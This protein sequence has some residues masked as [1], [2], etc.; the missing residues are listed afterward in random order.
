MTSE[1][2]VRLQPVS[3]KEATGEIPEIYEST[4]DLL[5]I[6]WTAAIFQG[7]AMYPALL[8]RAWAE[9]R[10][11]VV[12]LAFREDARRLREQADGALDEIYQP[13]YGPA[14]VELWGGDLSR[15]RELVEIFNYGNAKLFLCAT[16]ITR[17]LEG[18]PI[19]G[20]R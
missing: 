4:K 5:G 20:Q 14:E 12:T 9:L 16:A 1:A 17:S 19:A 8:R 11:S 10:P 15:I 6:P 7:Y 3:E 13:G 18:N 2:S